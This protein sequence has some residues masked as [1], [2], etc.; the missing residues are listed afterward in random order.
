MSESRP[1]EIVV[2]ADFAPAERGRALACPVDLDN[3]DSFLS[4]FRPRLELGLDFC[5]ELE[6]SSAAQ[7][8]PD[9]LCAL[10]HGLSAL[11]EARA[12]AHDPA[13]MA[14]LAAEAGARI[15]T[16]TPLAPASAAR[17]PA[18]DRAL[19]DELLGGARRDDTDPV[20]RLARSLGGAAGRS[21]RAA[22]EQRR[23]ALDAELAR[24]LRLLLADPAL[25]RL[26]ALCLGLRALARAAPDPERVRIRAVHARADALEHVATSLGGA[27]LLVAAHGFAAD[28]AGLAQLRALGALARATGACALAGTAPGSGGAF[29]GADWEKLRGDPAARDVGLCHPRVLA[30]LPYGAQT[31]AIDSFPFE[32]LEASAGP[33]SF[34]WC[35]AALAAARTVARCAT[36]TGGTHALPAFLD[37]G[38]L[39]VF[40]G[41]PALG[42][43]AL[44]PT[45]L[46]L[47]DR[48]AEALAARGVSP[49]IARRGSDEARLPALL[50]I[51]GRALLARSER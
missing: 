6:L 4:A 43:A 48:D 35:D 22:I 1:F 38:D 46:A 34:V 24:R 26:E 14:A 40:A 21:D 9:R 13:R 23:A 18:S 49:L 10:V 36:E 33:A 16:E 19:L 30:R 42:L 3:L 7:L 12:E 44:G 2:L 39:P 11:V 51:D 37:L 45:E 25:R 27:S 50:S 20:H 5:G 31:D 28:A 29:A 41:S 32:E 8:H 15:E 47:D 17:P